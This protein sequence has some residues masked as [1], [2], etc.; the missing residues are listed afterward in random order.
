MLSAFRSKLAVVAMLSE[1][2]SQVCPTRSDRTRIITLLVVLVPII[3]QEDIS[4]RN[5]LP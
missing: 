5:W 3:H 4:C 1:E 2:V